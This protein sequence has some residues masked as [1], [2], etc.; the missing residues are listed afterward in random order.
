MPVCLY[1]SPNLNFTRWS[2]PVENFQNFFGAP[3]RLPLPAYLN[4]GSS[5]GQTTRYGHLL[6]N[7]LQKLSKCSNVCPIKYLRGGGKNEIAVTT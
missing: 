5:L 1:S 6:S 4:C 3:Q 2:A 7:Q